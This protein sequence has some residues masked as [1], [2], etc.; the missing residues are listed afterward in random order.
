MSEDHN[1]PPILDQDTTFRV[2]GSRISNL[3]SRALAAYFPPHEV[4]FLPQRVKNGRAM[5]LAYITARAVMDRLDYVLGVDN[6]MDAYEPLPG[7]SV[8]CTLSVRFEA[9][10]EWIHKSDVGSP[11]EQPD[12]GDRTK[13]AFSDA[14]KRAAVKFGVARYLYSLGTTWADYDEQK[15]RWATEPELPLG[16]IP[17]AYRPAGEAKMRKVIGILESALDEAG[18]DRARWKEATVN[19]LADYGYKGGDKRPVENRHA[20]AMTERMNQFVSFVAKMIPNCPSS[21]LYNAN[22][23]PTWG[24]KWAS[25]GGKQDAKPDQKK[26]APEGRGGKEKA[27]K[28][29][30]SNQPT[31][32]VNGKELLSRIEMRDEEL[33]KAGRMK[34]RG[35]LKAHIIECGAKRTY[36]AD[37]LRWTAGMID[38]A[39]AWA[40]EFIRDLPEPGT[41]KVDETDDSDKPDYAVA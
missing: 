33:Y 40:T 17:T 34:F 41:Y 30:A 14:L 8:R 39:L 22:E 1:A 6:W 18:I 10:G 19:L 20:D 37:L 35:A 27:D 2:S 25:E 31:K 29:R 11:S 12:E 9:E 4:R 28:P 24:S 13:A 26:E 23:G 16:C 38:N 36:S 32:P 3:K 7:G 5:A 21:P 15:K